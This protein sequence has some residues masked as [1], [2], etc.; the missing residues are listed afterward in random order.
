MKRLTTL[1]LLTL[2]HV[3]L[4]AYSNCHFKNTHYEEV[5]ARLVKQGVSLEYANRFLLSPKSDKLELQSFKL[6]QPKMI[7][8]H[9]ANEKKANNTLVKYLPQLV[10][11][12]KKYK[13]VYDE[14]QKRFGV[15]REVIAAI[16]MKET[17]LGKITPSYDAYSVFNTLVLKLNPKT[18]RDRWLLTMAKDNMVSIISYCYN[19]AIEPLACNF[20]SS[21]AGAVGIPQ[22]MP[23]NFRY[24]VGYKKPIGNIETL[25]DAI[26]SVAK[27]LHVRA[28][29]TT[30]IDWS[31][32]PNVAK[33]EEAW[34]DFDF[35]HEK[36]SF[37]Y[38]KSKNGKKTYNCYA[39]EKE[40]LHYLRHYVKKIMRYNNSSNYAIGV[41][42][43]AYDAHNALQKESHDL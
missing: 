7:K 26:L 15:D 12:L 38:A 16:L 27:Y 13:A 4:Y 18:S 19:N 31:K 1:T 6:F 22:F 17:K 14:A 9:H 41:M 40:E 23:Q 39:C 32:I 11:H 28:N 21:Y 5:C 3:N 25:E 34:Y 36:S 10:S 37:V 43:L 35:T 30:P 29:Y 24:I 20:K 42:R 8:V 33:V 2:L